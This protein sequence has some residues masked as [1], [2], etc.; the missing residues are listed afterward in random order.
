MSNNYNK[1]Q[2]EGTID[3]HSSYHENEER[4]RIDGNPAERVSGDNMNEMNGNI[5]PTDTSRPH[6]MASEYSSKCV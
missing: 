2:E 3:M 5:N 4:L 1:L 6:S